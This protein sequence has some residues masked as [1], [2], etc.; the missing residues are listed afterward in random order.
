VDGRNFLALVQQINLDEQLLEKLA[1]A[2]HELYCEGVRAR[3]KD[4]QVPE[5][6]HL[7]EILIP[8]KQLSEHFK[9]QNRENVG[10]IPAKLAAAGYVMVPA[11]SNEMPFNFPGEDLERLAQAEHQRWMQ[12]KL[13]DGWR[14]DPVT[15]NIARTNRCLVAWQELDEVERQKDRDLVRGIPRILA[16]AGYAILRSGK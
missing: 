4:P 14:H 1:Q 16:R 2:A 6:T 5:D 10:D 9:Q 12:A 3:R 13:A 15:D 7:E 11:R 8:Y